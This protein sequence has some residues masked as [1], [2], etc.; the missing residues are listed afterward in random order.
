MDIYRSLGMRVINWLIEWIKRTCFDSDRLTLVVISVMELKSEPV[1]YWVGVRLNTKTRTILTRFVVYVIFHL[2]CA[3]NHAQTCMQGLNKRLRPRTLLSYLNSLSRKGSTQ[4]CARSISCSFTFCS[5][6]F[7]K[8][9]AFLRNTTTI[10]E[11]SKTGEAMENSWQ[12]ITCKNL[13]A[14]RVRCTVVY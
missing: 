2:S 7:N 4:L 12:L 14:G 5:K 1:Y 10:F 8:F 11:K 3:K 9:I 6:F 13:H